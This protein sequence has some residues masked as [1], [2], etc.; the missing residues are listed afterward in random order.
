MTIFRV[1]RIA[2]F[3]AIAAIAP[4]LALACEDDSDCASDKECKESVSGNKRCYPKEKQKNE[5][6]GEYKKSVLRCDKK[7]PEVWTTC[8]YPVGL[9]CKK[10]PQ[11]CYLPED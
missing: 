2:A 6:K 4:T 11:C 5:G 1:S 10:S 8:G 9:P 7:C 3:L